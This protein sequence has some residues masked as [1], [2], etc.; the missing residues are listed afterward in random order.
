MTPRTMVRKWSTKLKLDTMSSMG[1]SAQLLKNSWTTP[2][3]LAVNTKHNAT[4]TMNAMT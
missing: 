2:S 3:P 1:R 4:A